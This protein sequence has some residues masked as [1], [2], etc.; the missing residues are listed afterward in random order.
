MNWNHSKIVATAFALSALA[1]C[2]EWR[3]TYATVSGVPVIHASTIPDKFY[4]RDPRKGTCGPDRHVCWE[5][6]RD[7]ADRRAATGQ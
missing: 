2:A 1:G 7:D 6:N 4:V 3:Q 5:M